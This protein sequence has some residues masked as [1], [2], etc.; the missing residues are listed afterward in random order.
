MSLSAAVA[1]GLVLLA[2]S[3]EAGGDANRELPVVQRAVDVATLRSGERFVGLVISSPSTEN[4]RM[5]VSREWLKRSAP[6]YHQQFER[7]EAERT[8]L[9]WEDLC[10]RICEWKKQRP[11]PRALAVFL[12]SELERAERQLRGIDRGMPLD[13]NQLVL[14]ECRVPKC[15]VR[16]SSPRRDDACSPWRGTRSSPIRRISW[17]AR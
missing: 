7:F 15:S 16:S 17:P 12:E 2:V 3:G 1:S 5:L 4:L 10:G 13:A 6:I 11:E 9:A 8:R 14:I